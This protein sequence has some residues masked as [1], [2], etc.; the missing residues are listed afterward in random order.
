VSKSGKH[1]ANLDKF[2]SEVASRAKKGLELSLVC[3]I[4]VSNSQRWSLDVRKYQQVYPL[5]K[6][7]IKT[8]LGQTFI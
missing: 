8:I 3:L 7:Y 6:E 4:D 1:T 2:W 5:K